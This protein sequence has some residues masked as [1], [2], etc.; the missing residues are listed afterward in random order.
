MVLAGDLHLAGLQVLHRVVDPP[1][2]ELELVCLRPQGQSQDLVPQADA[3][4]GD[5]PQQLPHGLDGGPHRS[6]IA[7]AIGEEHAIGFQSQHLV[8]GGVGRDYRYGTAVSLQDAQDVPL[9]AE[10]VGHH[11]VPALTAAPGVGLVRGDL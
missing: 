5:A 11:L 9:D 1:V 6:R 8:G 10:V 4:D 2:A 3:K 7:G